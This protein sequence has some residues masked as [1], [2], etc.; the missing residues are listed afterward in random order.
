[1]SGHHPS[2]GASRNAS[3][4]AIHRKMVMAVDRLNRANSDMARASPLQID[5][6]VVDVPLA[7]QHA[8]AEQQDPLP[9]L[10]SRALH[11]CRAAHF[12]LA[13]VDFIER[14]NVALARVEQIDSKPLRHFVVRSLANLI[15]VNV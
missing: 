13:Q 1:M 12:A 8:E 11:A 4:Q 15:D 10:K 2:M 3:L 6:L 7:D 5:A 9:E 14:Q